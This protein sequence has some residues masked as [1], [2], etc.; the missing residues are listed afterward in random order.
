MEQCSLGCWQSEDVDVMNCCWLVE[1][2]HLDTRTAIVMYHKLTQKSIEVTMAASCALQCLKG[3][4]CVFKLLEIFSDGL[5]LCTASDN[6]QVV[7]LIQPALCV[8]LLIWDFVCTCSPLGCD[9]FIMFSVVGNQVL[10]CIVQHK[11]VPERVAAGRGSI[12]YRGGGDLSFLAASGIINVDASLSLTCCEQN[13]KHDD[14]TQQHLDYSDC[15]KHAPRWRPC[16][17]SDYRRARTS[18]LLVGFTTSG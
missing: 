5:M 11:S 16:D 13:Q 15:S 4:R 1:R 6:N 8:M 12:V 18:H 2:I 3:D 9:L 7:M 14:S 10:W 17:V